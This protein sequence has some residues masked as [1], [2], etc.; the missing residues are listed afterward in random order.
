MNRAPPSPLRPPPCPSPFLPHPPPPVLTEGVGSGAEEGG[1]GG[2]GR[3]EGMEG[4]EGK[5][6]VNNEGMLLST[7][8]ALIATY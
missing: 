3:R 2:E 7:Y 5:G 4:E 8:K 1:V 6:P